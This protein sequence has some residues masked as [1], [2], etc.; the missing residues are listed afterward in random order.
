[1]T[2]NLLSFINKKDVSKM[3]GTSFWY[4]NNGI[5]RTLFCSLLSCFA[6]GFGFVLKIGRYYSFA[7]CYPDNE[8]DCSVEQSHPEGE[9]IREDAHYDNSY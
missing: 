7:N 6:I 2:N 1:M 3:L 4:V 5:E 9:H 8:V